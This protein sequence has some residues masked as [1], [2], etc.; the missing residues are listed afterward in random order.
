MAA[1]A[2]V[3]PYGPPL[4]FFHLFARHSAFIQV[5]FS[6]QDQNRNL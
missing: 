4:L 3:S 1:A 5:S 6:R 2:T